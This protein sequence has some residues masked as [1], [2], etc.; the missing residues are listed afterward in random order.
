MLQRHPLAHLLERWGPHLFLFFD[1]QSHDWAQNPDIFSPAPQLTDVYNISGF[2]Q[3]C[4]SLESLAAPLKGGSLTLL[5]VTLSL[6]CIIEKRNQILVEIN[7][8]VSL[9]PSLNFIYFLVLVLLLSIAVTCSQHPV[10]CDLLRFSHRIQTP[11]VTRRTRGTI[12]LNDWQ[13]TRLR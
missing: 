3:M 1:L 2:F 7:L 8:C 4:I 13:A 5:Y 6:K 11:K 12:R 9:L 10:L